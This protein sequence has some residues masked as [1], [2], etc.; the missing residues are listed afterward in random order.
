MSQINWTECLYWGQLCEFICFASAAGAT[1]LV[2][3]QSFIELVNWYL[4]IQQ[5]STLD[6]AGTKRIPVMFL[7]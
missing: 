3:T 1:Q 4:V 5:D 2:Q 6:R 7:A